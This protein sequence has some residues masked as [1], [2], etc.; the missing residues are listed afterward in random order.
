MDLTF[1]KHA[2]DKLELFEI[3]EEEVLQALKEPKYVCQDNEKHSTIYLVEVRK[4]LFSIVVKE[5]VI[6]TVYRTDE[7][8]L[9]SRMRSGRWS[10]Y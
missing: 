2:K 5:G 3:R 6:I 9:H 1:S 7:K 8:K 4:K 10:C